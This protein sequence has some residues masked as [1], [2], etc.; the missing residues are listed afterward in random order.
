MWR[1]WGVRKMSRTWE[2]MTRRKMGRVSVVSVDSSQRLALTG[3]E[4]IVA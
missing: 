2:R 1:M 3:M 4:R